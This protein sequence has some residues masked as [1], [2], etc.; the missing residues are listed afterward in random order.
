MKDNSLN[1][2]GLKRSNDLAYDIGKQLITLSTGILALSFSFVK[3]NNIP[4]YKSLLFWG[5]GLEGLSILLGIAFLFSIFYIY[6][7]WKKVEIVSI[8]TLVLGIFQL[9]SFLGGLFCLS[10]SAYYVLNT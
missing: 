7:N 10:L 8:P 3:I 2:D 9:L 4:N 5:W 6:R 1:V